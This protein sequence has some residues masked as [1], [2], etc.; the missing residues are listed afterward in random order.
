MIIQN[1]RLGFA[2]NSSSTHSIVFGLQ[3]QEDYLLDEEAFGWE[4]F[5]LTS[6]EAKS[7]YLAIVLYQA[8]V[9][10]I[11]EPMAQ[12]VVKDWCQVS[13]SK[14]AYIDHQSLMGLPVDRMRIGYYGRGPHQISQEFFKDLYDYYMKKDLAIIGGNDNDRENEDDEIKKQSLERHSHKIPPE[15]VNDNWICRKDGDW[16]VIM[17]RFSGAKIRLSFKDNPEP[18]KYIKSSVPE[19]IDIKLTDF[20]PFG[21]KYCLTPD[22]QILTPQGKRPISEICIGDIVYGYSHSNSTRTELEVE[23][24]F[25]RDYSGD[26]IVIEAENGKEIKLTPE[27]EVFT[28]NRGYVFAA[29]LTEK[30]EILSF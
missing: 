29:N 19:L 24:L 6:K 20:C 25:E 16:W 17:N 21:C 4:N 12:A 8:I 11:G 15:Q 27:H 18:E 26:M 7:K 28:I 22:T 14:D 5:I 1:I 2:T 23:Q 13:V 3:G 9:D 10:K 30:D